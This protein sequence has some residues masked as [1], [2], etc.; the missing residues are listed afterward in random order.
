MGVPRT[1][2]GGKNSSKGITAS[3]LS[4]SGHGSVVN[5]VNSLNNST[6]SNNSNYNTLLTPFSL[7]PP[8]TLSTSSHNNLG[9]LSPIPGGAGKSP[10]SPSG[11][12]RGSA[13]PASSLNNSMHNPRYPFHIPHSN[14]SSLPL[15]F[16]HYPSSL[17][18]TTLQCSSLPFT[19][20][21][22]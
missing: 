22:S 13:S 6:N 11:N 14:Y 7:Q 21:L 19:P 12:R 18:F 17:P 9:L 3:S 1:Y 15:T 8:Q 5:G 16:P 20:H 10:F 2:T 4:A